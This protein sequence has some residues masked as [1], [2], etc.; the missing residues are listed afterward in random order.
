MPRMNHRVVPVVTALALAGALAGCDK[1]SKTPPASEP[2]ATV[3]PPAASTEPAP[4]PPA[5]APAGGDP[6]IK[7]LEPGG[8]PKEAL[9]FKIA[10]GTKQRAEM[11]MRMDIEISMNGTAVPKTAVPAIKMVMDFEATDVNSIGDVSLSMRVAEATMVEDPSTPPEVAA[12][13]KASLSQLTS[14]TATT[15][16]SDRG[17]IKQADFSLPGEGDPQLGQLMDGMKQSM[18]QLTAPLP[19]EPVGAGARWQVEHD[20]AQNGI[21]LKQ[22]EIVT[23]QGI[24]GSE[25]DLGIELTQKAGAQTMKLPGVPAG[26]DAQLVS[27]TSQGSGATTSDVT[28]LVPVKSKM[29]AKMEMKTKISAAGQV[30]NMEMKM[31]MDME[32]KTAK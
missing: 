8:E 7:L 20:I 26:V 21:N 10:K 9:R 27:M 29:G 2:A 12:A 18:Q 25:I 15:V 32:L 22:T 4:P 3:A 19:A 31:G 6:V 13:V 11:T 24:R 17:F 1:G 5:P 30:Q 23:L 14:L 16:V 28:K